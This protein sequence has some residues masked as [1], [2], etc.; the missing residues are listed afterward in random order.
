MPSGDS[1]GHQPEATAA[2]AGRKLFE[3]QALGL[4][5]VAEVRSYL[6]WTAR[7]GGG[8]ADAIWARAR[9]LALEGK[10]VPPPDEACA[11]A[12]EERSSAWRV[13][14]ETLEAAGSLDRALA[15][16]TQAAERAEV[17]PGSER[18]ATPPC[19]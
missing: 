11:P 2:L 8:R 14:G 1:S 19:R 7:A 10:P 16:Y 4:H 12:A 18:L 17:A 13:W 6:E 3:N 9:L 5:S 15:A